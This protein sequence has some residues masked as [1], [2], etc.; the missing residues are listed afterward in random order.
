MNLKRFSSSSL[1]IVTG[2]KTI[3]SKPKFLFLA[4]MPFVISLFIFFSG[5][6]YG[7]HYLGLALGW[8]LGFIFPAAEG[9]W[10]QVAYYPLLVLFW[11]VF[12]VSLS[13]IA[14]LLTSVVA[15]PFNALLA[16]SILV[17]Y[18]YI[19]PVELGFVG[20]IKFSIKM[21][22]IALLRAGILV[23]LSIVLFI[24]SFIPGLN[25]V[26]S[27]VAAMIVG[28]DAADYTLELK[29]YS[30]T[31]RFKSVREMLPEYAGMGLTIAIVLLLPGAV[32][33]LMP[34][35]VAGATLTMGKALKEV[36]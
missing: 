30:L 14:Y 29:N 33:I 13:A 36:E 26:T 21:L 6:S 35:I 10:Y 31:D 34:S 11:I 27:Y 5:L 23:G 24:L 2:I 17:H 8:A 4:S 9:I 15:A 19:E 1:F 28:F 25:I 7:S 20:F 3:F 16:E 32:L 22:L 18:K 12:L